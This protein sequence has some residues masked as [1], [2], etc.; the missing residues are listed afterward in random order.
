[1]RPKDFHL[2]DFPKARLATMDVGRFSMG[3]HYMFGLMEVDVTRARQNARS[4][5]RTGDGPSFTAWMIKAVGDCAARNKG[6]HALRLGKRGLVLFDDVDIAIPVERTVGNRGVPLP[7]LL[8]ATNRKT[9]HEIHREIESATGRKVADERDYILSTHRFSTAVLKLYYRLPQWARLLAYR[10]LFGNP[11]RA[12][13]NSGTV[14]VTTVGA[15]GS[16]AGWILPTRGLHNLSVGLGS[17]TRKPWVVGTEI[18]IRDILH[19][20]VTFNHDVIDGVPARRFVQDL[21]S[22]IEKGDLN[23]QS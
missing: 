7:L 16:A 18:R 12:K 10:W 17:V 8:K 13:A 11:F 5:R 21:V 15:T 23:E 9:V 19:L 6:A 2:I 22:V 20:T 1:M 14:L 3:K 4:L